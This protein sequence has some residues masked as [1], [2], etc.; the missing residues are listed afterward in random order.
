M[1][2]FFVLSSTVA[3]TLA[4]TACASNPT[5][6]LAIQKENNQ[7]EV[8]GIGKSNLIAKNNAISAA[9]TTCGKK[10][11]VVVVDEK[12]E[13]NGALKNVVDE[14]TGQMIQAAA[15]VIGTLAGKNTSIARDE[16][17][18]TVLTFTCRAN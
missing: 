7:Y 8:T 18:Q 12:T 3:M 13:Y 17:Y 1:N 5:N 4:L 15:S 6:S 11:T 9:N 10:A 14:Q 16:D 2:K